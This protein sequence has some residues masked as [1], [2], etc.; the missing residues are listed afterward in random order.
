MPRVIGRII[1]MVGGLGLAWHRDHANY[2]V[3]ATAIAYA[4]AFNLP[5]FLLIEGRLKPDRV[6]FRS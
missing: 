3:V 5:S 6:I 2:V 4:S 1:D